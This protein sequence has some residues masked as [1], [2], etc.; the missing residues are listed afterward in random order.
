M[1]VYE[2]IT[3]GTDLSWL[4]EEAYETFSGCFDLRVEEM[5]AGKRFD[6][7][8][9]IACL[10]RGAGEVGA[11]DLEEGAFLGIDAQGRPQRQVFTS[12][13]SCTLLVLDDAVMKH[14][15][16]RACWFHA[17][18]L[19]EARRSAAQRTYRIGE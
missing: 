18:F 14:V 19:E 16:Y 11:S 8:G 9:C 12:H 7:A 2:K 6:T 1:T 15:C 4:P 13:V 3:A 17:R 10:L 5:A